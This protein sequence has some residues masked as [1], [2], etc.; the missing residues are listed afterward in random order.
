M[1]APTAVAASSGGAQKRSADGI[2][3]VVKAGKKRDAKS[4]LSDFS[5]W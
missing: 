1:A 5:G 2:E 3:A 4:T